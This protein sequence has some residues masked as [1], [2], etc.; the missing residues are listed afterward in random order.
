M[1]LSGEDRR[2][3]VLA[4]FPCGPRVREQLAPHVDWLDVHFCAEDDDDAFYA[5]LPHAEVLWHVLRPLSD[6]DISKGE[7]L[8]LIHKFGAGVNTIALDAATDQGVAVANMPGANAPSVAEGALLLMLAALRQLPRLDRETRAGQ[9]WPTDQSL[10]D[11]VRDIGS[12]TVGLVGYGNIAKTLEKIL[13]AMGATVLHTSTRDDDTATWHGLD[14]LLTSSDIVS[15]HLPLTDKTTSMLDAAALG[16]MKPGSVLVNTSRG[17]VVEEAALVN[18]LR[19]G[20]LGAAGLDV[21]AQEPVSSDNPLLTLPNVV[22]TPHVT[23]F[24]A[25]TMT[26]YLDHAIANCRRLHDGLPLADRVR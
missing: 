10:G 16:R 1:S 22:V 20:P 7:R 9:G 8:R 19:Y 23:W 4:H 3:R 15:L 2:L 24:T 25:D 6:D 13:L 12:C 17:A 11:T 5:E 18:A 26:R 21:F 14:D